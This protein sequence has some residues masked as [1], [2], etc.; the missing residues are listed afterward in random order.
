MIIGPYM[1]YKVT[2]KDKL[3]HLWIKKVTLYPHRS[4]TNNF[5]R[6]W[7]PGGFICV[8][9]A[10]TVSNVYDKII[11]S[12]KN[13]VQTHKIWNVFFK[14]L[15][16]HLRTW[17]FLYYNLR[18]KIRGKKCKICKTWI[19]KIGRLNLKFWDLTSNCQKFSSLTSIVFLFIW[20]LTSEFTFQI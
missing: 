7:I 13:K 20:K 1:S 19:Q 9:I 18:L 12:R 14:N 16:K 5:P 11:N 8:F 6:I 17:N 15:T 2:K 3:T 4:C 10:A